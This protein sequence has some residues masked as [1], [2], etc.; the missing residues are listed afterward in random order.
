MTQLT[1]LLPIPTKAVMAM[2]LAIFVNLT[3]VAQ[4]QGK[5]NKVVSSRG[6]KEAVD[7][8]LE[9]SLV[10]IP[11]AKKA[12][13]LVIRPLLDRID[14]SAEEE[15][16]LGPE[17]ADHWSKRFG[18]K[19][20]TNA[21]D[22]AYLNKV[23][24]SVAAQ[25]RRRPGMKY[26]FHLVESKVD[27]AFTTPGGNIYVFRGLFSKMENEAEL[28]SVLGHEIAHSELEHTVEFVKPLIAI[29]NYSDR[30]PILKQITIQNLVSQLAQITLLSFTQEAKELEA[31]R[32]GLSFSF[33]AT[34]D[35]R[36]GSRALEAIGSNTTK[37]S[38]ESLGALT[39]EIWDAIRASHPDS[40]TRRKALNKEAQ[41]LIRHSPKAVV[42]IGLQNLA[43][44][45]P[46][47]EK[48]FPGGGG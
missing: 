15:M 16:R 2:L 34:Y 46:V 36:Q 8:V 37:P 32:L 43:E 1:T 10:A 39:K 28:A 17:I 11:G 22:V 38:P 41:S 24:Q 44:R 7:L 12:V 47:D 30:Y 26:T 19:L 48:I 23:G 4:T 18:D 6:S 21:L 25:A 3:L 14:V 9:K 40:P 13:R 45:V 5:F 33:K 27:N 31:D 35:P 42:H 20:D 29:R